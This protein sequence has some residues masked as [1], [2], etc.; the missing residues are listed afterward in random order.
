MGDGICEGGRLYVC[1]RACGIQSSRAG[2]RADHGGAV[3]TATHCGTRRLAAMVNAA[4]QATAIKQR[5]A[6]PLAG[7]VARWTAERC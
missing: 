4:D 5:S 1:G 7:W 3:P 2:L 6:F